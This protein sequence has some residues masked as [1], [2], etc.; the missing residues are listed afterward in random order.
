MNMEERTGTLDRAMSAHRDKA[1]VREEIIN[2]YQ[3]ALSRKAGIL[4]GEIDHLWQDVFAS[5][6][7]TETIGVVRDTLTTEA[8][9]ALVRDA[10]QQSLAWKVWKKDASAP[11]D[12]LGESEFQDQYYLLQQGFLLHPNV[13]GTEHIFGASPME[14]DEILYLNIMRKAETVMQANGL[15]AL[16]ENTEVLTE[17]IDPLLQTGEMAKLVAELPEKEQSSWRRFVTVTA[18]N[19]FIASAVNA[20]DRASQT[21][22]EVATALHELVEALQQ[23]QT[24][25]TAFEQAKVI[26]E[27]WAKLQQTLRTVLFSEK[28]IQSL[29][30]KAPVDSATIGATIAEAHIL[31]LLSSAD[32]K[33]VRRYLEEQAGIDWFS[34]FSRTAVAVGSA[35]LFMNMV[36]AACGGGHGGGTG[37]PPAG[38]TK[39]HHD[40][41]A[42]PGPQI[43]QS[44]DKATATPHPTDTP[45]HTATAAI[46]ETPTPPLEL[47]GVTP[48]LTALTGSHVDQST[49]I[50]IQPSDL[51]LALNH[52]KLGL[53]DVNGVAAFEDPKNPSLCFP[54]LAPQIFNPDN[55]NT[56]EK[57]VNQISFVA[58]YTDTEV[59]AGVPIPG[60]TDQFFCASAF[61]LDGNQ[62]QVDGSTLKPGTLITVLV[63]IGGKGETSIVAW[64]QAAFSLS[65]QIKISG[66]TV[67]VNDKPLDWIW[68]N[69]GTA[70]EQLP[71]LDKFPLVAESEENARIANAIATPALH[72]IPTRPLYTANIDT[73]GYISGF[74]VGGVYGESIVFRDYWA[75]EESDHNFAYN[76]LVETLDT[77]GVHE[78]K[79]I[80]LGFTKGDLG[81]PARI[82]SVLQGAEQGKM[83][84]LSVVTHLASPPVIQSHIDIEAWGETTGASQRLIAAYAAARSP[85]HD[86]SLILPTD[87][88]V[89][90]DVQVHQ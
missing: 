4:R 56:P 12:L 22:P 29:D 33:I 21:N 54:A 8:A 66:N 26:E 6:E 44:P 3:D 1:A 70:I 55:P 48:D 35:F 50:H 14:H 83:V 15:S 43:T 76:I 16:E 11:A 84:V 60:P 63:Q 77:N 13:S 80:H 49:L 64:R 46:T 69:S 68:L 82:L 24:Q 20:A 52:M 38:P 67:L 65:D 90:D 10:I 88:L 57:L 58:R 34:R 71:D 2:N 37:T 32:Q 19:G 36:L 41:T 78:F 9:D 23:G 74:Q 5:A 47:S 79:T 85:S 73:G 81:G 7:E 39:D 30:E 86:F 31:R 18:R 45:A 40:Q 62:L 72:T 27:G 61:A 53:V 75:T 42:T 59:L 17:S 51:Q 87:E 28:P 25:R 89:V